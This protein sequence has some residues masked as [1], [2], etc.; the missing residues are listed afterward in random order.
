MLRVLIADDHPVIRRGIRHILE[1]IVDTVEADEVSDGCGVIEHI[2]RKPYDI[3]LLDLSMPDMNG[4]DILKQIKITHPCL[5]VLILSIHREELYAI[6]ALRA[7]AS[8]YLT[9]EIAPEALVSAIRTIMGGEKYINPSLAQKLAFEIDDFSH[10][11]LHTSL[12]DRE[13]QVLQFI[14]SGKTVK[15]AA[16]AMHLSAKTV[17]TY[18]TRILEKL[19]LKNNAE[20]TCYAIKEDLVV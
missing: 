1:E 2:A 3:V 13:L 19:N 12:S 9:K 6:R 14:A 8:G 10:K 18:R 16:D 20:I 5:P 7:G 17:S 15:E 4:I 11:K